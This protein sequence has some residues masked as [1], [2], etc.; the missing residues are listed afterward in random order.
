MRRRIIAG[1]LAINLII[2][3]PVTDTFAGQS[4]VQVQT[5]TDVSVFDT[6]QTTNVTND[7]KSDIEINEKP[8]NSSNANNEQVVETP[9]SDNSEEMKNADETD[10]AGDQL[11]GEQTE[12]DKDAVDSTE[13]DK[14]EEI[15]GTETVEAEEEVPTTEQIE[16][17]ETTETLETA[18]E[19]ELALLALNAAEYLDIAKCFGVKY[20]A[21]NKT[22]QIENRMDF[23]M[24]SNCD[25]AIVADFTINISATAANSLLNLE[26]ENGDEYEFRGIGDEDNPFHGTI[27]S[28][29]INKI[30]V[31]RTFFGGLRSDASIGNAIKIVWDGDD[32]VPMLAGTYVISG[33]GEYKLPE[34]LSIESAEADTVKMGGLIGTVKCADPTASGTLVL[35]SFV[36]YKN[37]AVDVSNGNAGLICNTLESGA[38]RLKEGALPTT[39]WSV[40]GSGDA[41]GLIGH[42]N[43]GTKLEFA[44]ENGSADKLTVTSTAG[45]AGGIAGVIDD[46]AAVILKSS[47]TLSNLNVTGTTSGGGVAGTTSNEAVQAEG[48]S[49]LIMTAPT[50]KAKG[51]GSSAGGFYGDYTVSNE[52]VD[53]YPQ[54]VEIDSVNVTVQDGKRGDANGGNAGGIFGTF[55]FN[56]DYTFDWNNK[57]FNAKWTDGSAEGYG[58]VIGQ[59][60]SDNRKCK[61]IL[62]NISLKSFYVKGGNRSNYQG[63]IIG[64]IGSVDKP[65]YVEMNNIN[66]DADM[67]F[68]AS[69]RG[70][71]GVAGQLTAGSILKAV[72]LTVKTRDNANSDFAIW[73]GG[74]LVGYAGAGS[75][76][77][78]S[79]TTDISGARF[80]PFQNKYVGQLVGAQD[81]ALIYARGDGNGNGWTFKRSATAYKVNDIGNYGEILRLKDAGGTAVTGLSTDLVTITDDHIVTMKVPSAAYGENEISIASVDDFALLAI[82]WNSQGYFS[83]DAGNINS[84]TWKNLFTKNIILAADIDLTGTGIIG[85]TRDNRIGNDT[86]YSYQG[87]FDGRGN[88]IIM[89]AGETFGLRGDSAASGE[90][91]GQL[92]SYCNDS[93]C[94]TDIGLFAQAGGSIKDLVIKGNIT[95]STYGGWGNA[96]GIAGRTC[97]NIVLVQNV[98]AEET[99]TLMQIADGKTTYIGGFFGEN[100]V[101][102]VTIDQTSYAGAAIQ[103]NNVASG[104][105]DN[106]HAGG[107]IGTSRVNVTI[108]CNSAAV[109]GSITSDSTENL[110]CGGMIAT[111]QNGGTVNIRDLSVD[112]LVIAAEKANGTC[113]GFLGYS[114]NKVQVNFAINSTNSTNSAEYALKVKNNAQINAPNA[115]VGGLVYTSTGKSRWTVNEKGINLSGAQ[116][117]AG[118]NKALGLLVCHGESLYLEF[119]EHWST[120]Y[121]LSGISLSTTAAIFDELVAYTASSAANIWKNGENGI[122]SLATKQRVGVNPGIECTTYVN[123]TTYG[124]GKNN[125]CSRYYYDLDKKIETVNATTK[126]GKIDT[127]EELL[128]WSVYLYANNNLK[129]YFK[130]GDSGEVKYSIGGSSEDKPADLNMKGLSYYPINLS[131]EDVTV[132]NAKITFDNETIEKAESSNKSTVGSQDVHTQHYAMHSGLFHDQD[133]GEITVNVKNVTFSGS[134]GKVADYDSGVLFSGSVGGSK[135]DNVLHIYTM[136]LEQ[137]TLDGLTVYNIG[138]KKAPMLLNQ[139]GSYIT[140][141]VDTVSAKNYASPGQKAAA[142]SL[143]GDVGSGN[144]TQISISFSNIALP[145][146]TMDKGGIFT[147][148]TLLN[149]FQYADDGVAVGTYNFYHKDDYAGNTH[150]HHNVTYGAEITDAS[151][152]TPA[153]TKE[154]KT[155]Q[156]W[157][158]DETLHGKEEGIVK[159]K[160]GS[161]DFRAYL[162]YVAVPYNMGNHTHELKIN[163]RVSNLTNG[164]GTYGH[165]YVITKASELIILAEY[166]AG[167]ENAKPRKDWVVTI[168]SDQ[169]QLCSSAN[170]LDVSYQYDGTNWVQVKQDSGEWVEASPQVTLANAVMYRYLLSAYYDI[171]GEADTAGGYE[172]TLNNFKGLGNTVYPFRGVITS[173]N[174]TTVKLL[175][176]ETANGFIPYSYGS[177]IKDISFSYQTQDGKG[178]ALAYQKASTY[179]PQT[180]FGGVIG[181][182][183]GGDNIIDNVSVTMSEGWLT[184]T[185]E[186]KYLLQVGGFVGSVCGGGVIFRNMTGKSGLADNMISSG[187]VAENATDSLYVNP[188]VGRVLDGFAFSEGCEVAN[189]NKNYKINKL[190]TKDIRVLTTTGGEKGSRTFCFKTEIKDAQ[191][192]LILSAL[193]NSGAAAGSSDGGSSS[194]YGGTYAYWGVSYQGQNSSKDTTYKLGNGIY[195]K[196]RNASYDHIGDPDRAVSDFEKAKKDDQTAPGCSSNQS[197]KNAETLNGDITN[198]PYLV[199]KYCNKATFYIAGCDRSVGFVMNSQ[200]NYNMKGYG[201]GYQGISARYSSNALNG[202]KAN[203]D[204][205]VPWVTYFKGENSTLEVDMSVKEY[206]QDDFCAVS[207]GGIYNLIQVNPVDLKGANVLEKLTIADSSISIQYYDET[208]AEVTEI[209]KIEQGYAYEAV[210]VGGFA[211]NNAS[212]MVADTNNASYKFQNVNIKDSSFTSPGGAGG[213]MG[214][215]GKMTWENKFAKLFGS[216]KVF[217]GVNLLDCTYSRL[218]VNG[219]CA[220][221]GFV[222]SVNSNSAVKSSVQFTTAGEHVVDGTQ[223]STVKASGL[224]YGKEKSYAGGIFGDVRTKFYMNEKDTGELVLEHT[225]VSSENA[226]GGVVGYVGNEYKILHTTFC[227]SQSGSATLEGSSLAGGIVGEGAANGNIENCKVNYIKI[228]ST[229]G[230]VGRIGG[231][232]GYISKG[233]SSVKNCTVEHF[234][235]NGNMVGGVAGYINDATVQVFGCKVLGETNAQ[236]QLDAAN[237]AGGILAFFNTTNPITIEQCQV[238]AV[239]V[240]AITYAGGL[241]ANMNGDQKNVLCLYD[242]AVQNSMITGVYTGGVVGILHGTVQGTN[243]LCANNSVSGEK[244]K[245]GNIFGYVGGKFKNVYLSGVSLQK[246]TGTTNLSDLCGNSNQLKGKGYIAFAD[247]DGTAMTA[248]SADSTAGTEKDLLGVTPVFPYVTTSPKSSLS[249]KKGYDY[250]L[251]GDSASWT[252]ENNAFTLKAEKIWNER[253]SASNTKYVYSKT[254]VSEFNFSENVSTYNDMQPEHADTDFPVLLVTSENAEK[255]IADYLDIVTNGGYS[256]ANKLKQVKAEAEVYSYDSAQKKF[257]YDST[258]AAALQIKNQDGSIVFQAPI[259]YDNNRNRFTLLTV[260]F[261]KVEGHQYKVQV[262][263]I[264]RRM[265]QVDFTATLNY[266]THFKSTDYDNLTGHVLE[267]FGNSV[268]AYLTYTYNSEKGAYA[269]YGWKNYVEAGGDATKVLEKQIIFAQDDPVPVGTQLTLVDCQDNNRR[270]YS[271]TTTDADVKMTKTTISLSSFTNPDGKAFA[272]RSIGE[273][274]GVQAEENAA[275][276]FLE[277]DKEGIPTDTEVTGAV[278]GVLPSVKIGEKYYRLAQSGETGGRRY[279]VTIP[280]EN[281]AEAG[282]SKIKENYYLVITM[283]ESA[284]G[285]ANGAI[286]TDFESREI[287]YQINYELRGGG[288]DKQENTA[289]TYQISSGY[290]QKLQDN[291]N[292]NQKELIEA[293]RTLKI[294]ITDEITFP[295]GQAYQIGDQLYLRF[296]GSLQNWITENGSQKVASAEFPAG[297]EGQV[298][299]YIYTV[300][301]DK[302]TYYSDVQ[303]GSMIKW[304][305]GSARMPV[306]ADGYLWTSDGGN[307]ELPLSSDGSVANAI[308]LQGVRD[309][310]LQNSGGD[311]TTGTFYVEAVLDAELPSVG[312]DVIPQTQLSSDGSTPID[313]AKITYTSQL[314]AEKSSLSYSNMK[315][316]LQG[317]TKYYRQETDSAVLTYDADDVNQLGINPYDLGQNV[318][319]SKEHALID[320]TAVY[321]LAEVRD[322]ENT[323]LQSG[324]VRFTLKV[325]QKDSVA[326]RT[327]KYGAQIAGESID[328]EGSILN[329]AD[330][331]LTVKLTGEENPELTYQNGIWSWTIPQSSYVENHVIKTGSSFDG[332]E[333]MQALQLQVKVNNIESAK[334]YYS[335][336]KVV[337][338]A[339]ILDAQG[340]AINATTS[341]DYLIYTLAKIRPEFVE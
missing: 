212:N 94:H 98:K 21:V 100:N 222:G 306:T 139:L 17:T 2:G 209:G 140:V 51:T 72:N 22:V 329:D 166:L 223:P 206:G 324:G 182:I 314:S 286:Q 42:M 260:T 200:A 71:G 85:L 309:S 227:G 26:K 47:F 215:A 3:L 53:A 311:K 35:G 293:Y 279:K 112:G 11:N 84:Q 216:D 322:L 302:R 175:G 44:I 298:H 86:T 277:T 116:I 269:D 340:N 291:S 138:D 301:G 256:E 190:D 101:S 312:L 333:F 228:N 155:L 268:T 332:T 137:I 83:A 109:G 193:I 275:G 235:A 114:W 128:I 274:M 258:E 67:P 321:D 282:K 198:A 243:L 108:D 318:D 242:S 171:Q 231:I 68:A 113:G 217:F 80:N 146:K 24:L 79:G 33:T 249:V 297:T 218:T 292:L 135:T 336:Y 153:G 252:S 90:G 95:F 233:T 330:Q 118:N 276:T 319:A 295:K 201:N 130:V 82:T 12:T 134:I 205:I 337:V 7:E 8:E 313:Y 34:N 202:Q 303:S 251:Y 97:G 163:Q 187:S 253:T 341:E 162:P 174:G 270:M 61:L 335:N 181:C 179:Y 145:D 48:A 304:S 310:I 75:V 289:S 148:A 81:N 133:N 246:G 248:G 93:N 164:C 178:K 161:T 208:G 262:P 273:V 89:A 131:A 278:S 230:T 176:S 195:G 250:L 115:N 14:T 16:T 284:V 327:E 125:G 58:A 29:G 92:Y 281:L 152:D 123:R 172:L 290:Q 192:L 167:G 151:D 65:V 154:Y 203:K 247:Y 141:S 30:Q 76:L 56:T 173:S 323:L 27:N 232:V 111:I 41:G 191:G 40:S 237:S 55:K 184:L 156:Q 188:Y 54:Y 45:N 219:R 36:S 294:C 224:W 105:G 50:V 129:S 96:G 264:V 177:V 64:R 241:V 142:S 150:D 77:E 13:K 265:L 9:K 296:I 236:I 1:L 299:F 57:L 127:R 143:I 31:N 213:L 88:T 328:A 185:G 10:T 271:Y 38:I 194:S 239:K 272:S 70:F 331:Y 189:T 104:A 60:I 6:Q 28:T 99:I 334:H 196:V 66:V 180:C 285:K 91:S 234:N 199:T 254:G 315:K 308:S 263:L 78:L 52:N 132:E 266:G 107:M 210:G 170:R 204:R 159:D 221:G 169:N 102:M 320:T 244:G 186:K 261:G 165:P 136:N 121:E 110:Y 144:G 120:A 103:L 117:T 39:A 158:Y 23:I 300:D 207:A 32:S 259:G 69:T 59:V 245:L 4:I 226:T 5:D 288:V 257:V 339:E 267:S 238:N 220:A 255:V 280:E 214:N 18:E 63:G 147:K 20:N 74:G 106:V 326:G 25:P 149:S 240:N 283:P 229:K 62:Q 37:V 305:T 168:T 307:M 160:D 126:N 119:T 43:A 73:E 157:Y 225:T 46:G 197:G 19:P 317:D 316:T 49:K 122:I 287:P 15:K 183:M 211:G 325:L 87:T 338:E 124:S